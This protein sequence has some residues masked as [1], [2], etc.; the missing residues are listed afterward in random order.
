MTDAVHVSFTDY[1]VLIDQLGI[2]SDAKLSGTRSLE[3]TRRYVG[4]FF[5]LHLR[6]RPQPLLDR[7]SAHYP[8]VRLCTPETKTCE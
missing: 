2:D 3:I 4:A 8:E 5:D 7:P 1:G 6:K